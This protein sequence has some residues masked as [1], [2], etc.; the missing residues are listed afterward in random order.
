VARTGEQNVLDGVEVERGR[1]D[2]T[3]FWRTAGELRHDIH[4]QRFHPLRTPH[5]ESRN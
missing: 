1:R 2:S 4:S 3:I 5:W